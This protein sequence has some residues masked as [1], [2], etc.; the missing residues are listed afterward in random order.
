MDVLWVVG[1]VAELVAQVLDEG[2]HRT[3]VAGVSRPPDPL[4]QVFVG[5]H[6]PRVDR[7]LDEQPVFDVGQPDG[8][9]R[10][11]DPAFGVVDGQLAQPVRLR[12]PRPARAPALRRRAVWTLATSSVGEKGL[13]T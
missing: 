2:A 11:R 9:A 4:Q 1:V 7:Q 13:T 3:R 12:R 6:T 10:Q 8:A 5:Q